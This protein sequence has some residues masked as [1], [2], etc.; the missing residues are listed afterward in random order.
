MIQIVFAASNYNIEY[1]FTAVYNNTMYFLFYLYN[2]YTEY[3]IHRSVCS[4]AL[5][6][7]ITYTDQFKNK[8]HKNKK[9]VRLN[10]I[11][12]SISNIG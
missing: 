5:L 8:L 9:N 3:A 7:K 4:N 10:I 1:L 2:I 6:I 11:M 12:T